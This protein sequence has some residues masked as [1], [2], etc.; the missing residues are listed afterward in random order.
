MAL[1]P[2][3][4]SQYG[5]P[6]CGAPFDFKPWEPHTVSGE[7]LRKET[8]QPLPSS[9][10]SCMEAVGF[11]NS[12]SSAALIL[13]HAGEILVIVCSL[14]DKLWFFFLFAKLN[15]VG[16]WNHLGSIGNRQCCISLLSPLPWVLNDSWK[17][18]L[19]MC[20]WGC[21]KNPLHLFHST[22][23]VT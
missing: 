12:A 18:V 22:W 9:C 5:F 14:G 8:G 3:P 20:S 11:I 1:L 23:E 7:G 4:C 6:A 2:S 15:V 21:A 13:P 19:M 17:D 16:L 10:H